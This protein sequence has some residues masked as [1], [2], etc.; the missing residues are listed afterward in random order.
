MTSQVS[1]T[2]FPSRRL[3]D[4]MTSKYHR[5][6][7][8]DVTLRQLPLSV[9][10]EMCQPSRHSRTRVV[11]NNQTVTFIRGSSAELEGVN[12]L[13]WN[14]VH[15]GPPPHHRLTIAT[16]RHFHQPHWLFRRLPPRPLQKRGLQLARNPGRFLSPLL[17]LFRPPPINFRLR[18]R[19]C[20]TSGSLT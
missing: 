6:R 19:R 4:G 12:R 14:P 11:W 3:E 5:Q 9:I 7:L 1:G 13:P 16:G 2:A 10:V 8:P 20:S 18:L 17:S 15:R